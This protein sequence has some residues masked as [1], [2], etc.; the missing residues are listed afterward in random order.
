MSKH[1]AKHLSKDKTFSHPDFTVG[2]GVSPVRHQ[3]DVH[4]L[5]QKGITV[6][7]EFHQ[8]PKIFL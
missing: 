3:N 5:C 7:V 4:G 8:P 1:G 6:G 2:T